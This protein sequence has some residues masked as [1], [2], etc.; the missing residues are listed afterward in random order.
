MS[1]F[2]TEFRYLINSGYNLGLDKYPIFDETYRETLNNLIKNHFYFH[3]IGFES[4]QRFVFELNNVMR[5]IMPYYNQ[6]YKAELL[7]Y[8]PFVE[9]SRE[10]KQVTDN[11]QNILDKL[12][13]IV[14]GETITDSLNKT[15]TISNIDSNST[16]NDNSST[17]TNVVQNDN[18]SFEEGSLTNVNGSDSSV[19]SNDS[20]SVG[21]NTP[22]DLLNIGTIEN[23]VYATTATIDKGDSTVDNSTNNETDFKHSSQSNN[24]SNVETDNKTESNTS[25]NDNTET[26]VDS[27]VDLDS[28]ITE[29]KTTTKDNE[30]TTTN[31]QEMSTIESGHNSSK[32]K[33]IVEFRDSFINIDKMILNDLNLQECFMMVYGSD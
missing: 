32:T 26:I 25:T 3:E 9:Y 6:L 29:D 28:T 21:S 16:Q 33:L 18:N 30:K 24:N 5:E 10:L 1:D 17:N 14:N 12:V 19:S 15:D 7:S 27:T 8:D 20:K 11:S 22:K 4:A 23:N 2:T 13:E 31:N